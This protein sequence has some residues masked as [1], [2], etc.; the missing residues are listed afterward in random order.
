MSEVKAILVEAQNTSKH[1]AMWSPSK[2]LRRSQCND[3]P[4]SLSKLHN[5]ILWLKNKKMTESAFM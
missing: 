3:G 4:L 5:K 1:V 2:P